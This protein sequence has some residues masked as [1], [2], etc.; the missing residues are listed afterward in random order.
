MVCM[1]RSDFD[2]V[3]G[4]GGDEE[5]RYAGWG[6]EDVDLYNRFREHPEYAVFRSLE[7]ELLHLWHGKHCERNAHYVNCMRTVFMTMASQER[8]AKIV[9]ESG[10]DMS[11]ITK[12]AFPL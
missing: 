6:S 9:A 4:F 10:V 2:A 11:S 8:L 12:N 1:F 3:R 7:P 5:T